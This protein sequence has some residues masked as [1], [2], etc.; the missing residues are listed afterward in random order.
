VYG[1][2][3]PNGSGKS[4]TIGM[5]FGLL[6]P[7]A[8]HTELFGM[9]TRTR[10]SDAL[11]RTG[12]TLEGNSYFPHLSAIDNLKVWAR[13]SGVPDSRIHDVIEQ[14]GMTARAKDKVRTYSLGMKQRLSVAAALLND[15]ELVILD[16]PT[17]GLDPAGI[18][19]FRGLV[20]DL[21]SR[22]KTIFVSSH[23]L[24]EVEQMCDDV[25]IVKAGRLIVEQP[26]ASL[27]KAGSAIEIR[28]TDDLGALKILQ[29]LPWVRGAAR[30]DGRIVVQADVERAPEVSRALAEAAI[31][32]AEM[33]P[34]ESTLEDFFLEV[35]GEGGTA[36]A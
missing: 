21:A 36:V 33:R 13:V 2:L 6:T 25:G 27:R 24:S 29:Q 7:T 8:G 16:E 4:T 11:S 35:T 17:N 31:Y 10:R 32:L 30:S 19:E 23:I 5:V 3:G 22:G 15:P 20:R 34:Q 14:V 18:R 9:D 1:F 28:T 26:V 12:A